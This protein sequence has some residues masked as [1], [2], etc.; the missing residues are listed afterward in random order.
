MGEHPAATI[1]KALPMAQDDLQPLPG[2]SGTDGMAPYNVSRLWIVFWAAHVAIPAGFTAQL[3]HADLETGPF[4]TLQTLGPTTDIANPGERIFVYP[5][6][7]QVKN[8][9]RFQLSAALQMNIF[10]S[11][12]VE[13]EFNDLRRL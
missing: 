3:Q 12:D 6:P 7:F 10:L 11:S 8:W 13:K 1:T 5:M 4:V 2:T 9:V